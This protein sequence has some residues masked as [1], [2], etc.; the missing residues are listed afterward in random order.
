[1]KATPGKFY[2]AGGL[3]ALLVMG[4]CGGT[5]APMFEP[6]RDQTGRWTV[7]SAVRWYAAQPWITGCNFIPSTAI[8]QLEMWQE[9]TF[10]PETIDRELGWA[11]DLGF[12]T[13][14][15]FLHNLL[16]EQDP[17]GF[18]ERIGEYLDIADG[19]GIRT[20]F[21]LFDNVW[22]PTPALG[23]QPTPVPGMHNSGWVQSPA[24]IETQNFPDDQSIQERMESYVKG[25]LTA[26]GEDRRVLM[27]DLVNEPGNT[28]LVD[29][30]R[31]LVEA[32]FAWGREVAPKQPLSAGV[33]L[34][35]TEWELSLYQIE[36]SD[37][38]TFHSYDDVDSFHYL[39]NDMRQITERPFICTEY[40]ARIKDSLFQTH[41]PIMLDENI[42]AINWGL[43]SG[44]TQ[45]IYPW[46][47]KEGALE[48]EIWFH[49]IFYEDGT[50]F[51]PD[52]VAF[53]KSI[54]FG[55]GSR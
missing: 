29:L 26:F 53:I 35:Q 49:D 14:R 5:D 54:T 42:G 33:W 10:D 11:A 2:L 18:L 27:W 47:S 3:A 55:A 7:E 21:V 9:D 23:P 16:W 51:D 22:G 24:M 15:V 34:M 12:N 41:M 17:D 6:V 40:M 4:G 43:V 52:E 31:P 48:P 32:S 13:V 1:M 30:A 45:T 20:M 50:P 28:L 19:H 36:Q 44:K 25:I 46:N 37:V 39:I 8:N 38:V